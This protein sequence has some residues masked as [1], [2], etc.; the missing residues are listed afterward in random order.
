[1]AIKKDKEMT[2]DIATS[3]IIACGIAIVGAPIA[4]LS[5]FFF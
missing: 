1:M 2:H 4:A 3:I 5:F